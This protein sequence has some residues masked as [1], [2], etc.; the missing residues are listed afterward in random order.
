MYNLYIVQYVLYY[1]ILQLL[2][3]SDRFGSQRTADKIVL[4]NNT[5]S[6][7]Y[8][9]MMD[10]P[11]EVSGVE[12]IGVDIV[13]EATVTWSISTLRG[14]TVDYTSSFARTF[15][16]HSVSLLNCRTSTAYRYCSCR[17]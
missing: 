16:I 7:N 15:H 11:V 12:I 8:T 9:L 6:S 1:I 5:G 3:I 13:C 17:H 14:K 2:F 4:L 10:Q